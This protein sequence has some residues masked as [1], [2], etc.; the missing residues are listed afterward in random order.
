MSYLRKIMQSTI[1][2]RHILIAILILVVLIVILQFAGPHY[3]RYID[4]KKKIEYICIE[5]PDTE[6]KTGPEDVKPLPLV[7]QNNYFIDKRSG[8]KVHAKK[9][10][11]PSTRNDL[12]FTPAEKSRIH[13]CVNNF[14]SDWK[15]GQSDFWDGD[16]QYIRRT[17]HKYLIPGDN[18]MIEVG[19][20]V[21][22]DAQYYLDTY[23]P[24]H[25]IM[26]EPLKLLYR[27]LQQRF[28]NYTNAITYNVGL[29]KRN[30]KFMIKMEGNIGDASSPFFGSGEGTCSLK[31][32]NAIDFFSALGVGNFKVDL[33][34]IN[35]EG[36]EYDL[37]ETILSTDLVYHFKHIQFGTH[38]TL[39]NLAD[40]VRRY[41]QIQER[42]SRTH[43]LTYQYKFTWETWKL[44][45]I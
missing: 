25:Y 1:Q 11:R 6:N 22:E 20:N 13:S 15:K 32:I 43:K 23:K 9:F 29:G 30:E 21:G 27:K 45:D 12:N 4:I 26:L 42:L 41:C 18:V 8:G 17:H 36:C 35:C 39:K 24:K 33:I 44:K 19:G 34:T 31:V 38:P 2:K 40:P 3:C 10:Y 16:E 7:Y 5:D 37:L 14:K 28:K